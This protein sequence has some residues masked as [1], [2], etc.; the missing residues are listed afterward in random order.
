MLQRIDVKD[1][2]RRGLQKRLVIKRSCSLKGV[3][4][5]NEI[6]LTVICKWKAV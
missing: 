2:G 1:D 5:M 6:A 3:E 4:L